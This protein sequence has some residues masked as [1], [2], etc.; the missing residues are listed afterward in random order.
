VLLLAVNLH[1]INR[2]IIP[3]HPQIK[4]SLY[5]TK[6]GTQIRPKKGIDCIC[7]EKKRQEIRPEKGMAC[8]IFSFDKQEM[9]GMH[10]LETGVEFSQDPTNP[11]RVGSSIWR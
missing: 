7:R 2:L 5:Q 3:T 4:N 6:K 8:R 9:E 1:R 10:W 11:I